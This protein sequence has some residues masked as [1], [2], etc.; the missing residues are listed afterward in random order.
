[1]AGLYRD[2][3]ITYKRAFDSSKPKLVT[4]YNHDDDGNTD[5][6]K[7]PLFTGKGG[8]EELLL[9][10]ESFRNAADIINLPI[11]K[12][13][14]D[15]TRCLTTDAQSKWKNLIRDPLDPTQLQY[16]DS[17]IGGFEQVV[18]DFTKLYCNARDARDIMHTYLRSPECRKPPAATC[19]DHA[20]RILILM[21]YSTKLNGSSEPLSRVEKLTILLHS[22][23]SS[24]I[25]HYGMIHSGIQED[26]TVEFIVD[27]MSCHERLSNTKSS[28][29]NPYDSDID[30]PYD[31]DIN[32]VS[33]QS[34]DSN[35][36]SDN[37]NSH[38]DSASNADSKEESE[39]ETDN[40]HNH[41]RSYSNPCRITG[42][43]HDWSECPK[44]RYS[45]RNKSNSST[46]SAP[47]NETGSTASTNETFQAHM[48]QAMESYCMEHGGRVEKHFD[49][50][51]TWQP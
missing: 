4:L 47:S 19:K 6:M 26:T 31:S 28:I 5:S 34:Y 49:G 36:N 7:V 1:M 11:T 23:P 35:G 42:H 21:K 8:L 37:D 15:F 12:Y 13:I 38:S 43:D 44:N 41:K 27:H 25:E 33:N 39:D 30:N 3:P 46:A 22:F 10:E 20:D 9:V 14:T 40:N 18:L 17:E 50:S 51:L 2:P 48:R 29:D 32:S 16:E 24:W 45:K